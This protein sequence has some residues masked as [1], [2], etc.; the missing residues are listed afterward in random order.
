MWKSKWNDSAHAHQCDQQDGQGMRG[1]RSAFGPG[2]L[3]AE[4]GVVGRRNASVE[5]RQHS[6]AIVAQCE[7][8]PVE[9]RASQRERRVRP[10]N[11]MA[12]STFA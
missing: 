7:G 2:R 6:S 12:L 5:R 1:Y 8:R 4:L 3:A 10:R 11:W 9:V